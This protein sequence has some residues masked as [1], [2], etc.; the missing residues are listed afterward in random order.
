MALARLHDFIVTRLHWPG[1]MKIVAMVVWTLAWLCR[2]S[3]ECEGIGVAAGFT[4][5]IALPSV[6][7]DYQ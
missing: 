7:V 3:H 1:C 4:T 6:A 2:Y 5:V